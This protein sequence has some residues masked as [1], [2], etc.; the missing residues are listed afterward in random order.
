MHDSIYGCSANLHLVG[1]RSVPPLLPL[2]IVDV[3]GFPPETQ[4]FVR[5]V[6]DTFKEKKSQDKV[7]DVIV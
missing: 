7:A 1:L 5:R 2:F 6:K 4:V 3:G